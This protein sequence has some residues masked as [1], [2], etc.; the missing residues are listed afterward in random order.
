MN[1]SICGAPLRYAY[2]QDPKERPDFLWC[3]DCRQAYDGEGYILPI[4]VVGL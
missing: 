4:D 1:C 3:R 2:L